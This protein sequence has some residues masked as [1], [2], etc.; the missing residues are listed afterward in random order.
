M[1]KTLLDDGVECEDLLSARSFIF[2]TCLFLPKD[3]VYLSLQSSQKELTEDFT[4][5]WE[6]VHAPQFITFTQV[7]FLGHFNNNTPCPIHW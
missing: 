7:P 3:K 5:Y 4:Q 6:K 1:L 2:E